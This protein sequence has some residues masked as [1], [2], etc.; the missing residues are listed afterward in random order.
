MS[1]DL[2]E[3]IRNA[4]LTKYHSLLLIRRACGNAIVWSPAHEEF[5]GTL[6]RMISIRIDVQRIMALAQDGRCTWQLAYTLMLGPTA[7]KALTS[8]PSDIMGKRLE[9]LII[10]WST[11]DWTDVDY[12]NHCVEYASAM[13]ARVNELTPVARELILEVYDRP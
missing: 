2:A 5:R 13:Y 3:K 12:Y 1:S 7:A 6:Y 4:D 9:E 8:L 11:S 10:K